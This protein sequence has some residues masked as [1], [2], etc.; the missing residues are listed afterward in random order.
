MWV[1]ELDPEIPCEPW[2]LSVDVLDLSASLFLLVGAG[3]GHWLHAFP[4]V[5]RDFLH[6]CILCGL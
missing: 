6:N 2:L 3:L 5:T 4:A 1:L